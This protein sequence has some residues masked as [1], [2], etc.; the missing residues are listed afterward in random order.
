MRGRNCGAPWRLTVKARNLDPLQKM[1]GVDP[2]ADFR[3]IG[4]E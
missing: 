4:R 2:M 1:A 3:P